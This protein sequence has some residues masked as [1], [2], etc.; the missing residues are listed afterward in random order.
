MRSHVEQI[1]RNTSLVRV[2][3]HVAYQLHVE[4][5]D[6]GLEQVDEVER[7][8]AGAHVVERNAESGFTIEIENAPQ[9]RRVVRA[10]GLHD[11]EYHVPP[12]KA[13]GVD[14]SHSAAQT[15]A[16]IVDGRG[17]E[18]HEQRRVELL[19]FGARNGRPTR[20]EIELKEYTR[21]TRGIEELT[22]GHQRAIGTYAA[23][24]RF[25]AVHLRRIVGQHDG[26]K[27]RRQSVLIEQSK[28]P[29]A[30]CAY[31]HP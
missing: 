15:G 17:G 10:F 23:Q 12:L 31:D 3:I 29:A 1:G 2:A 27:V 6:V 21:A 22:R 24:Q 11:F 28:Q 30:A 25:V 18:V 7:R 20:R 16:R 26:L 9:M 14:G 13:R 19:P 5:Q 8:V 4:L